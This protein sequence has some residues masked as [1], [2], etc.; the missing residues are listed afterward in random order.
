MGDEA[1]EA[2]ERS[3]DVVVVLEVVFVGEVEGAGEVLEKL[4]TRVEVFLACDE[5]A[6]RDVDMYVVAFEEG[7]LDYLADGIVFAA[8]LCATIVL[9]DKVATLVR[10]EAPDARELN[11]EELSC[12]LCNLLN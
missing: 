1:A 2:F 8:L 4:E 7:G 3:V 10:V 6:A 12:I 11:S 5:G 9:F